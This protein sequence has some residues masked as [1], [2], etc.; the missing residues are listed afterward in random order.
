MLCHNEPGVLS[1]SDYYLITVSETARQ[2]YYYLTMCG[3]YHC[4][5]GYAV[6]RDNANTFLL[7][8]IRQGELKIE[9][10]GQVYTAQ[11]GQMV[12]LDCYR[13]H[14]YFTENYMEF[15]WMHIDGV[16][17][18]ALCQSLSQGTGCFIAKDDSNAHALMYQLI[19]RFRN[20]QSISEPLCARTIYSILCDL[21]PDSGLFTLSDEQSTPIGRT[22]AYIHSHL[23][24]PL[25]LRDLAAQAQL[26][27]YYFTRVFK[28]A[29]GYSPYEYIIVARLNH[30]KYLLKN[31]AFSIKEISAIVGY[32]S[33]IS[34][35]NA[36]TQKVGISPGKFRKFPLG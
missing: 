32:G 18:P 20:Q 7:L 16:N 30:A 34:F 23:N 22:V 21:M 24:D 35:I 36:F 10:D 8:Y 33:E 5:R 26:S 25:T 15:Y 11:T 3:H 6:R 14:H 9:Y 12:L 29:T 4:D 27:V 28:K 31:S 17:L 19:S 2:L 13:A 1:G